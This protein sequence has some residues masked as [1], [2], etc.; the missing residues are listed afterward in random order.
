MDGKRTISGFAKTAGKYTL[1]GL[2]KG[3]AL[4]SRGAVKTVNAIATNPGLRKIATGAGILAASLMIPTVGIGLISTI[5]MKYAID[6]GALGKE[7]KGVLDEINDILRIG[8]D[9]TRNASHH[10]I[11]PA[12]RS[13]DRGIGKIDRKYQDKIDEMFR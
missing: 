13:M 10:I 12:L 3:V 9:I 8:N 2:G 11:S 1:K 4:T 5:G 6:K 7:N